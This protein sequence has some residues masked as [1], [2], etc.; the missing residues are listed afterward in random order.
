M[1]IK[2]GDIVWVQYD[3]SQGTEVKKRRPSVVLS[4]NILNENH[5]RIL[6]APITSKLKKLYP[7]EF[8][9]ENSQKSPRKSYVG[10]NAIH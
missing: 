9:I 2:K 8:K 6:V 7:F 4:S 3:P 1:S 10:P 5:C